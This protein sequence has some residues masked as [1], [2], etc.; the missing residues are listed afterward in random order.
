MIFTLGL[1]WKSAPLKLREQLAVEEQAVPALLRDIRRLPGVS[2]CVLLQTC[3]RFELYW[4]AAKSADSAGLRATLEKRLAGSGKPCPLDCLAGEEAHR[5]LLEVACGLHSQILGEEQVLTQVRAAAETAREEKAMS[6]PLETLFRLA[7]TAGKES[8]TKVKLQTVP[9]SSAQRALEL[10]AQILGDLS[11]KRALVIGNGEMGRLAARL[12]VEAGCSVTVTLRSYRHGQTIVPRGCNTVAYE[13]RLSAMEGCDIL[14]SATRSPH[15]TVTRSMLDGLSTPPALAVDMALPRDLEP[16][17]RCKPGLAFLDLDDLQAGQEL[18]DSPQ[19]HQIRQ[20]IEK[21]LADFKQ[22]SSYRER[23]AAQEPP[24]RFPLFVSLAGK[25][26]LVVGCGPV[27]LRRVGVLRE[28]G[29]KVTV[30]SPHCRQI[31]EG[32]RL[33]HRCFEPGDTKG[34]TLVVAATGNREINRQIALE[35]GQNNI[36]VSVADCPGESSFYFPAI[37]QSQ[38]LVA[39]L[40]SNHS[41]HGLVAQSAAALRQ[42]MK[43]WDL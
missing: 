15:Y 5:H 33:L 3:N 34:M 20:I 12:L 35:C 32:V 31:P 23:R 28:F 2:G 11:G 17:C 26:C 40:V 6:P 10:A 14:V 25:P 4:D 29:A 21:Y 27:G 36:P 7:V 41:N 37:C 8:R 13:Q 1:D 39:G 22:W 24:P 38:H 16:E 42:W 43:E 9:L 30:I 19:L 18:E